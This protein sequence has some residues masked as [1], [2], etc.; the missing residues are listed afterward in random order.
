MIYLV[1]RSQTPPPFAQPD[2]SPF[3]TVQMSKRGGIWLCKTMDYDLL[4]F[5]V[6][7]GIDD[8]ANLSDV[9]VAAKG[10]LYWKKLGKYLGLRDSTLND[11]GSQHSKPEECLLYCLSRWLRRYDDVD[12][13]GGPTHSSLKNALK[14]MN[15]E[16]IAE[17]ISKT[18]NGA[19]TNKGQLVIVLS[20]YL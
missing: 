19:G 2:S 7:I 18:F 10:H 15:K 4:I 20:A 5:L 12:D 17:K 13:K 8:F 6:I 14:L 11:I 1:S 9:L 3:Y 16:E